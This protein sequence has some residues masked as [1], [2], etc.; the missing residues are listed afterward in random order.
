MQKPIEDVKPGD[1]ISL[2]AGFLPAD[3]LITSVEH[4]PEKVLVTIN[5]DWGNPIAFAK[6]TEIE[7]A[8]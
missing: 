5:S 6:G 7:V 3:N 8:K 1:K 2:W 4:F